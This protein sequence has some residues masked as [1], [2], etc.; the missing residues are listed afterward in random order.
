MYTGVNVGSK[1]GIQTP[2]VGG[3]GNRALLGGKAPPGFVATLLE[4]CDE[5]LRFAL[6]GC[7]PGWGTARAVEIPTDGVLLQPFVAK[8]RGLETVP[9][10]MVQLTEAGLES[11]TDE[12]LETVGDDGLGADVVT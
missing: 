12:Q 9:E 10:V 1:P 3:V 4:S 2:F 11:D 6:L 8:G 5:G 7:L